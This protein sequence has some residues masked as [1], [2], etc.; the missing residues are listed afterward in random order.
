MAPWNNAPF[1]GEVWRRKKDGKTETRRVIDR[2]IGGD[3]LYQSGRRSC[4]NPPIVGKFSEWCVWQSEA[5]NIDANQQ[6]TQE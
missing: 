2:T 3:V 4:F 6:E 1:A 5:Q